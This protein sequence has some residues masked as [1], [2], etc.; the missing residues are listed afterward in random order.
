MSLQ[1][2]P[3]MTNNTINVTIKDGI[4]AITKSVIVTVATILKTSTSPTTLG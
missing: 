4:I 2:F 1:F 3:I